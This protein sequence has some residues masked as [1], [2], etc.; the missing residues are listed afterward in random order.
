MVHAS[1]RAF[2]PLAGGPDQIH[3]ALKDVLT[4]DGTV[5]MYFALDAM[6]RVASDPHAAR[7]FTET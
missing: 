4:A 5:M 6:A 2:G 3:L 1:I 7:D